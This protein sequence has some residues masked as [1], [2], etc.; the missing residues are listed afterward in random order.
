MGAL[1]GCEDKWNFT[2][3]GKGMTVTVSMMGGLGNQMFQYA[4]GRSLSLRLNTPLILDCGWYDQNF[5]RTG[6]TPY[7]MSLDTF[8]IDANIRSNKAYTVRANRLIS[9]VLPLT[10]FVLEHDLSANKLLEMSTSSRRIR[11]IGYWQNVDYFRTFSGRIRQDFALREG[12]DGQAALLQSR[13]GREDCIGVHIRLGDL[14][15]LNRY[16]VSL[17]YLRRAVG[18]VRERALSTSVLL[19][20]DNPEWCEEN[21]AES[22]DAEVVTGNW[23]DAVDLFLYSQCTH[24][25]MS[26]STFSWWGTWLGESDRQ[27]VVA[28]SNW[29]DPGHPPPGSPNHWIYL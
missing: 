24:H 1:K 19:F 28:P 2:A 4:A 14:A 3:K 9:R 25:V 10:R 13:L 26:D 22:L 12:L 8:N 27:V 29:W 7:I 23:S 6:L 17:E 18:T 16:A 11:L 20:S 21:L 5:D 15:H